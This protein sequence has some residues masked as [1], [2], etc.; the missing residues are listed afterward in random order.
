M[1]T[2]GE[3]AM[4]LPWLAPSVASM[5]ALARSQLPSVWAQLRT[6]PGVVLLTARVLESS[7]PLEVAL[8][9][10]VLHHQ[11]HLHLG[12]VD[13]N[14]PGPGVVRRVCCQQAMLTGQLAEKVGCDAQRAWIAGFLAPLGWL[15]IAAVQPNQITD[16]LERLPR[17]SDASAWQRQAWGHDHIALARRLSRCWRLP[18]WLASIIGNVG[19]HASIAGRLGAEPKLFQVVQLAIALVQEGQGGLGLTLG[20]DLA[21][22]LNALRLKAVEVEALAA[23][24]LQAELPVQTWESLTRHALLPD[25][26]QLA[27]DNRRQNDAAWI[28]RLQQDL[29]H[30]QEALM[31][32]CADEQGRLQALKLSALAEFAA[33][34]GHEINNPL[35]VISGQ[36]QYVL[37][38]MDWLDVPAEEIDNVGE[39]LEGLRA[40]VAP[41]LQKIIGQTQRVHSIL[42]ELMQFARPSRPNLQ[43]VS[44]RSLLAEVADSLEALAQQRKV[45]LLVAGSPHDELLH[46]DAGQARVALTGLLRNAIEAAPPEGWAR[47]RVEKKSKTAL[48][49]IVE[50]NGNGPCP[51]TR[52]HLFDPFFSG[53]SAGRGRGMG[54]PIAWRLARQ[55][56]G[57]VRFDGVNDG[58]TRF[59]LT[60]PLAAATLNVSSNGYHT[61][62]ILSP[63]R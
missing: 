51:T 35:A 48:D 22:L 60:L 59:V 8:L 54:L 25:L 26:L 36:A 57:D 17:N 5:T 56:G 63:T 53:R 7:T 15:A 29:D 40:K 55:Q 32:Q 20:A 1:K 19:L 46:A 12:F 11:T 31:H 50:D 45:Q 41:S 28:D 9:E 42:T 14:E 3:A 52:E 2:P 38:Q 39:Y 30:L 4:D 10:S 43:S 16:N 21:D 37:K 44:V 13:W 24:I 6:D 34:A 23:T 58:V 18:A 61:E 27:L 47:I 62:E 33:G 49:V